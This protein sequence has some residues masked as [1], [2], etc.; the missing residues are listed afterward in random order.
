MI[1]KTLDAE[2]CSPLNARPLLQ[3]RE[4][5]SLI[6][7]AIED[8]TAREE[9]QAALPPRLNGLGALKSWSEAT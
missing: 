6:L 8:V 2:S 9:L 4:Q 1:L 5:K 7:L 3:D